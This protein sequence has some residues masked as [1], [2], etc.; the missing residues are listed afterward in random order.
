MRKSGLLSCDVDHKMNEVQVAHDGRF[1][2]CEGLLDRE[3]CSWAVGF[4]H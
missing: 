4:F 2:G 1:G 3:S